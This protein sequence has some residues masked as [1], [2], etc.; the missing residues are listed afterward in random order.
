METIE[1]PNYPDEETGINEF[2]EALKTV[3]EELDKKGYGYL[4]YDWPPKDKQNGKFYV[5]ISK[6]EDNTKYVK[7]EGNNYDEALRDAI[8]KMDEKK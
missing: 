6:S 4:S 2:R 8:D 7:G 5:T 3:Q 1:K